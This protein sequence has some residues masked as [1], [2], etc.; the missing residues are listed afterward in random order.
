MAR[1]RQMI[2]T[3]DD[4]LTRIADDRDERSSSFFQRQLL[5]LPD[6]NRIETTLAMHDAEFPFGA[7][8]IASTTFREIN[9]GALNPVGNGHQIAGQQ[10]RVRGFEICSGCGKVLSGPPAAKQ[11]AYSCRYRD[12]PDNAK[13]RKLLFMYR[14]FQS[15]ALRFLLPDRL[16]WD[17]SG[18]SSFQAALR[19]GLKTH[20][21]GKVDHLQPAVSS[22]PQAPAGEG[23]SPGG[24]SNQR[25][26]FLYLYDS[27]PGGTG[28]LRQLVEQ[29]GD[30]LRPVFEA[31]RDVMQACS[32]NDGCYRC[33]FAYRSRYERDRISKAR[34]LEQLQALRSRWEQLQSSRRSLTAVTITTQVELGREP[35]IDEPSRCDFLITPTTGGRAIAVYTDGWDYHRGRLDKDVR[36]RMAL[37]RSGRYRFWGLCWDD[38][39]G[40]ANGPAD[41]LPANGLL[42]GLAPSFRRDPAAFAEQWLARSRFPAAEQRFLVELVNSFQQNGQSLSSTCVTATSGEAVKT[43]AARFAAAGIATRVI[44]AE[45]ADDPSDNALRLATMHRVK[46]LEF[47]HMLIPGLSAGV[48]PQRRMLNACPDQVS[49]DAFEQ[50]ER[51]LLHVAAT[52]ARKRVVITWSGEPSP[53][54]PRQ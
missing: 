52:R 16:F 47:D 45:E 28:Y 7:E 40:R 25:K 35:G 36:Q 51:S 54:L 46:G 14:E 31:A 3:S 20:F 29:G 11:H 9:F 38:V 1:L 37:Q 27:I 18:Q 43:L 30:R 2:A 24:P 22:E 39:V 41:P 12:T 5:I 34:A 21:S 50:R 32:C 6:L 19:L 8:F 48:L 17:D 26:T 42:L 15:E 10:F 4:A 13:V 44:T 23:H 33:L 49:R 53:Y